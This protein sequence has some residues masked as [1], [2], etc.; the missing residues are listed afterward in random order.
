MKEMFAVTTEGC[1]CAC[2]GG[3]LALTMLN[4]LA[5]TSVAVPPPLPVAD[6]EDAPLSA[7]RLAAIDGI[8]ADGLRRGKMPGCVVLVGYRG[9]VVWHEAY[10]LKRVAP[11]EQP[12]QPDTLFDLA[13]LT[14]PI[15]TATSVMRLIEEGRVEL[16]APVSKYLPT[17]TGHGKEAITIRHLL[18]HQGGLIPDNAL[19]DY[20]DGKTLAY[21]RIDG[22]SLRAEPGT[23]FIYSDVGFIVLGRLVET[24]TGRPLNEYAH[25]TIFAPLGMSETGFRPA[26]MLA[27]RAA[28]TEKRDG[29]WMQ[30]TV[31]DPRAYELEGV[32]GHAG[33]FS[34]AA[35]LARYAQMLL[36]EGTYGGVQVLA[37]ET[38][39]LMRTPVDVSGGLRGL[40]WDIQTAYSSNR[41]DL[42]SPAAFG[43]GGFTGTALWIDPD[44]QMFVIFLSNRVHPDGSG[45][46]NPLIGRIA[47]VAA[48][49]VPE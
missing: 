35:D 4:V 9:K 26:A 27:A 34:T 11:D 18:T 37:P 48:A 45:S 7:D 16:D 2:T 24:I 40:G 25:E 20:Q 6:P 36:N 14:K 32:A 30:G 22:L 28:P 19:A 15:A 49:A 47:T 43:H 33:L 5:A 1:R 23:R 29:A 39:R 38:V 3:L 44:L 10:G 46:V 17:F 12:M 13:S 42:F 21:E 41:G 31:H 8:V